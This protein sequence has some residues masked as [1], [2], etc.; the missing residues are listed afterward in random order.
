MPTGRA[1]IP[2]DGP[3]G[4]VTL[5]QR[6]AAS[7]A[8]TRDRL[9]H[10]ECFDPEQRAELYAILQAIIADTDAHC[11]VVGRWVGQDARKIADA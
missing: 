5:E 10:A 9:A 2:V 6:L 7:L 1:S 3:E 8:E 4:A 11:G